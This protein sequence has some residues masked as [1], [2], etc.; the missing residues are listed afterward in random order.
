MR[1][2]QHEDRTGQERCKQVVADGR[3]AKFTQTCCGPGQEYCTYILSKV[4][5]LV[6]TRD[7][8]MHDFL[9]W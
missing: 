9:P 8:V 5:A 2:R 3:T 4:V 1:Q 6:G 7:D